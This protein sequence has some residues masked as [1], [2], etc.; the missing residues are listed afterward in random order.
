M[1]WYG[2][3]MGWGAGLMTGSFLLFWGLVIVAIVLLVRHLG[4][5]GQR[6]GSPPGPPSP[7][8]STAEQLLAER[9]A[10]GEIDDE[11]FHRRLA[12]LRAASGTPGQGTG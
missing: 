10:R 1:F 5:P 7:P 12:T 4:R 11:E 9:F 6:P 3:G 8:V 2:P